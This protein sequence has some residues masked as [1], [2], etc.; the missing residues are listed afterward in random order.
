MFSD[1]YWLLKFVACA[2]IV[3][4]GSAYSHYEG[5]EVNP[6]FWICQGRPNE[7]DGAYIWVPRCRVV[8]IGAGFFAE[9]RGRHIRLLGVG[10]SEEGKELQVAGF[11]RK[12]NG[13]FIDVKRMREVGSSGC[14]I[15]AEIVS[16]AAAVVL[17]VVFIRVFAVRVPLLRFRN[18]G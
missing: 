11:F 2:A 3:L 12:E 15:L 14:R 5:R 1:K 7:F 17:A 8:K 10:P 13:G 6:A 18:D 4:L 9:D 16:V